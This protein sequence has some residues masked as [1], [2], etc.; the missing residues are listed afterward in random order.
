MIIFYE[1]VAVSKCK[2]DYD[3]RLDLDLL[4]KIKWSKL[5]IRQKQKHYS[6]NAGF[7]N[8]SFGLFSLTIIYFGKE[9]YFNHILILNLR[10]ERNSI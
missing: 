3:I 2:K 4:K 5:T 7:F 10:A 8:F 9:F 1:I 6:F